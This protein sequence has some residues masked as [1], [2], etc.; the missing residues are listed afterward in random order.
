MDTAF[1]LSIKVLLEK[2]SEKYIYI[3][4]HKKLSRLFQ[5]RLELLLHQIFLI[6]IATTQF[7]LQGI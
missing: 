4:C 6:V 3:L 2:K 5:E 7:P 1:F